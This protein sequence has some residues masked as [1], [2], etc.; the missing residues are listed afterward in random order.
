MAA[1]LIALGSNLGDRAARLRAAIDEL[2]RL[3][4]S[5]RVARSSWRETPPVGGPGRQGPFLNGAALIETALDPPAVRAEL[6]RIERQGERVRT[7]RWDARTIDL[8]LL[9]VDGQTWQATDLIIP[10]PRMHYRRFVLEP[11]AEL[12]PWMIHPTSGWTISRLLAQ[13]DGVAPT[14]AVAATEMRVAEQLV[15]HLVERLLSSAASTT[16]ELSTTVVAWTPDDSSCEAAARPQ[17]LLAIG[18]VAGSD[19][20]PMRK[21]LKLPA[22][23]PVA[24]LTP[25]TSEAMAAEAL[26]VIASAW[27]KLVPAAPPSK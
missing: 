17:L 14:I 22:T 9:L 13:L 25:G 11:A 27:P 2:S 18:D 19:E 10:H 12:A 1:C 6:A 8:D 21:M 26:T 5:R 7:I 3:P 15:A 4:R 24:W 23:G 16:T 20:A